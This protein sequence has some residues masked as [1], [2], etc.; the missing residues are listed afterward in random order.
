MNQSNAELLK[1]ARSMCLLY[2]I[3]CFLT[4][5]VSFIFFREQDLGWVVLTIAL[6][7]FWR[8]SHRIKQILKIE[9]P[10][11]FTNYSGNKDRAVR[12]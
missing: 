4:G 5:I 6:F 7:G 1:K 9:D 8:I 11:F 12:S 2:S 3:V 10:Q